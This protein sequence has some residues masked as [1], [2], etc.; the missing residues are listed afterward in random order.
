MH[1]DTEQFTVD[2]SVDG[3][4]DKAVEHIRDSGFVI[5]TN[6]LTEAG[7][8]DV[9]TTCEDVAMEMQALDPYARGNRGPRRYSFGG[10]SKT[11]QLCHHWSFSKHLLDNAAIRRVVGAVNDGAVRCYG[12]GGEFV[13]GDTDYFQRLHSDVRHSG[14]KHVWPPPHLVANF[15]IEDQTEDFGPTRIVPASFTREHPHYWEEVKSSRSVLAPLPRGAAVLRD[16]RTLHSGSPNLQRRIR[17][18]PNAEY[19]HEWYY[20]EIGPFPPSVPREFLAALS[21]ELAHWV[22]DIVL[23]PEDD[24]GVCAG[25]ALWGQELAEEGYGWCH[26]CHRFR[27]TRFRCRFTCRQLARNCAEPCDWCRAENCNGACYG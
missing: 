4:V 17:Y 22:R 27:R 5:I 24:R 21:E 1:L 15:F 11:K 18:L 20:A 14:Y 26:S 13:L 25:F 16:A 8:R 2:P 3:W 9:R 6:A 10:A 23:S 19:V 12:A 7:I